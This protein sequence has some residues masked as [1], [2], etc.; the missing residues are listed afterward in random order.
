M[1][2]Q[3]ENTPNK[4]RKNTIDMYIYIHIVKIQVPIN[5]QPNGSSLYKDV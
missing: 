4:T 2:L 5:I 1:G 3:L